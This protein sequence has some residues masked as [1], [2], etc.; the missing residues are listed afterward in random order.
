MNA[1]ELLAAARDYE[2]LAATAQ[3]ELRAEFAKRGMEA[4]LVEDND[5]VSQRKLVTLRQYR[6]LSEAIVARSMLEASG[7]EVYLRDEN[8]VRLD[9]QVSNFIG[10]IRLQVEEAEAE[11]ARELLSQSVPEFI[12][13]EGE[14]DY[15]QPHCPVC[16][17]VE[18]TFEGSDRTFALPAVF[19]VGL[20][21]PP[22][23]KT[24]LCSVCGT[25]WEDGQ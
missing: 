13:M 24:W 18:I 9:W 1:E 6:D 12:R 8:L 22:G 14:P 4:P 23:P 17:S 20:P 16:G 7:I 2:E 19:V 3:A 5:A 21:L 15:A 10:G 25:R 11:T